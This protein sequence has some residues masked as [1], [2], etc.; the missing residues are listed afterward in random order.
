MWIVA[1]WDTELL[2]KLNIVWLQMQNRVCDIRCALMMVTWPPKHI[3][4]TLTQIEH[5]ILNSM[6]ICWS[7]LNNMEGCCRWYC[8]HSDSVVFPNH[9]PNRTRGKTVCVNVFVFFLCACS[10]LN[11]AFVRIYP[12][13]NFPVTNCKKFKMRP[14]FWQNICALLRKK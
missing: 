10:F 6:R 9:L 11:C 8:F 1:D 5:I 3:E 2:L 13:M 14:L 12:S 7:V 4:V